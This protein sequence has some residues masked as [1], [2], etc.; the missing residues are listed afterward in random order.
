MRKICLALMILLIGVFGLVSC[1]N[2]D[3]DVPE[4]LQLVY[5]SSTDGYKF[6][7]PEGWVIANRGGVCA[8]YVTAV[9]NTSISF[10]KAQKP[11]GALADYFNSSMAKLPYEINILKRE[12]ACSFGNATSAYKYIYTYEYEDYDFACMQ[13]LVM[14]GQELF[15]FTYNSYGDVEDEKSDYRQYLDAVQLS[16]D[17]FKFTE[18][19]PAGDGPVY[20]KDADGYNLVSDKRLAGFELYL[21]DGCL[22]I[23]NAS[24]VSAKLSDGANISISKASGTGV[25]IAD[26]WKTRKTELSAIVSELTVIRENVINSA[27]DTVVFGNLASNRVAAYEYTYVFGGV[28]YHVYQVFGVDSFNGYSFTYTATESE[29]SEHIDEVKTILEKVK[30]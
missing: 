11:D 16:I 27:E 17:N 6:Y 24:I 5:E 8:S 25:S 15:I 26:Y 1:A 23:D 2:G 20:E 10:V 19:R 18:T 21:P 4:G 28:T 7:G 29:Y 30:F 14:S 3:E 9:N 22:V 12:E 13:I